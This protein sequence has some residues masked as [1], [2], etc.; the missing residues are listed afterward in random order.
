M[1]SS[2]MDTSIWAKDS[3]HEGTLEVQVTQCWGGNAITQKHASEG[4]VSFSVGET[5]V[6]IARW[7]LGELVVTPPAGATVW[8]DRLMQMP[9]RFVLR[10][11]HSADV[12]VGAF[13][14]KIAVGDREERP[15]RNV[16]AAIL[17]DT[18]TRTFAGSGIMHALVLA[19]IAFFMPSLSAADD[20]G[21]DRRRII[22][23]KAFLD[24]ADAPR[25]QDEQK[26]K[27]NGG[28]DSGGTPG[29]AAK[30]EEGQMGADK[31]VT[32]S[33][34][35]T[36]KGDEKPENPQ[37]ARDRAL[38]EAAEFG[39]IGLISSTMQNDPNA[40]V[41][42]WGNLA[43]GADH[44]SHMGGLWGDPGEAFGNGLGLSG[45]GIGGGGKGEGIGIGEIGTIGHCGGCSGDGPGGFGH[46]HGVLG[47]GHAA[48]AP[49]IQWTGETSVNGRLDPAV[50]QRIVR[51]NA[52]RFMGCYQ[53]G[54]RSNPS[55]EGRVAV[56]FLIGRD[57]T[58][59][60]AQDT[61]GSDLPDPDVR[62]CVVRSFG[63]LEFP[64]P[65]G[66]LVTVI[67]PFTFTPA[68]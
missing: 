32:K 39:M 42:P 13:T 45:V 54:L 47:R 49:R 10:A 7:E 59:T 27:D 57:G 19:S 8:V 65:K 11:G 48:R 34:R 66:G 18:G 31:P 68:Q 56:S 55:L 62:A 63:T 14:F 26:A 22:D 20:E 64:E 53:S 28:G 33:G 23:L 29:A 44:D 67:Y 4:A 17:E 60:A 50:I 12:T 43:L 51:L 6:E 21:I 25:E 2:M 61:S 30:N 37:L 52:G 58:V 36:L 46:G 16:A 35:W 41:V 1:S 15:A 40:P 24:R 9:E 38:K 5:D 3:A